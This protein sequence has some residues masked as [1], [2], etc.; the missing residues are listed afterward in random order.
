[1]SQS[2]SDL[3][4][5]LQNALQSESLRKLTLSGPAKSDAE[6]V[7]IDVRPVTLRKG[8]FYQFAS[9]TPTQE[10]HHNVAPDSFMQFL[11]ERLADGY[12]NLNLQTTDHRIS[13]Q[14]RRDG[15]W[16]LLQDFAD[17]PSTEQTPTS[18]DRVRNYLI[19]EGTPCPFLIE[20]G[21]MTANGKVRSSHSRKFRQIN[22][23]LEF[24]FDIATALPADR[25]V[26]IVD[27]GC[28]KSYLTF[29]TQHLF[30]KVLQRPCN[31]IGLDRRSDVVS[32]CTEITSRLKLDNLRFE[33]GAISDFQSATPPDLVISL[34]ACDTATDDALLQSVLW[35]SSAVLA[36]PCC[37]KELH[38]T[39]AGT[40]ALPPLTS[41]GIIAERFASLATDATRAALMR[42]QGYE[43]QVLEFIETDHT[44]KNLLI[45]SVRRASA[46]NADARAA[47]LQE[48][49]QLRE[50]LQI[51]PLQLERGLSAAGLLDSSAAVTCEEDSA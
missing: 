20:T 2:T 41:W 30:Q 39:L 28:G 1:M 49:R 48:V 7:R 18:H 50:Q 12:Q 37:Q 25:P 9:R 44:P 46:Q 13:G 47:A 27:F 19:P 8:L 36:V 38:Q 43:T 3:M 31:L 5:L 35:N 32:T 16:K 21:I 4:E 33:T 40:P 15:T 42:T 45:R 34:H 51:G 6:F 23:F 17:L 24:I 14:L 26:Q 11:S 29:A 10:F 22:R